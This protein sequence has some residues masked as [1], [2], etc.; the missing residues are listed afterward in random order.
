MAGSAAHPIEA[1]AAKSEVT[2]LLDTLLPRQ[3]LVIE[4]VKLREMSLDEAAKA[5]SLS[6]SV[7]KTALHRALAKLRRHG[8]ACDE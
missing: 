3:R 1:L 8:E 5:T 4:L 6:V 2:R 7:L